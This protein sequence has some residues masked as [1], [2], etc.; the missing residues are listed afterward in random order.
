MLLLSALFVLSLALLFVVGARSARSFAEARHLR[1]VRAGAPVDIRPWMTIPYIAHTYQVP[2][3]ELLRALGLAPT[4]QHR[5]MPLEI[6]ARR[7]GRDLDRD[8]AT[9]R[10][11]VQESRPPSAPPLPATPQGP[12]PP[13]PPTPPGSSPP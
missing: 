9:I 5:R 6:I 11:V 10:E 4:R 2:E 7:E 12:S 13:R 3:D 1:A 8:L